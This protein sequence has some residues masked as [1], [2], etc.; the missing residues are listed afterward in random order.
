[1]H[2][3]GKPCSSVAMALQGGG[4]GHLDPPSLDSL[5]LDIMEF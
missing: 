1:M 2:N 5:A 4:I 3:T